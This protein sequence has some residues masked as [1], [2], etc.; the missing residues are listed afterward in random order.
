MFLYLGEGRPIPLL[1]NDSSSIFSFRPFLG[2]G[3]RSL[4]TIQ[5]HKMPKL[6]F[7]EGPQKVLHE[8]VVLCSILNRAG[9]GVGARL[10]TLDIL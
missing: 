6:F 7:I 10:Q 9:G 2:A 1:L 3:S 5:L 4:D 8:S